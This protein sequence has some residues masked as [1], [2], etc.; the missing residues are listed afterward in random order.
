MLKKLINSHSLQSIFRRSQFAIFAITFLICTFTFLSVS[1]LTVESY[2]KQNLALIS[3]TVAERVQPALVF[4]DVLTLNEIID[5]Y[6]LQYEVKSIQVYNRN[7]ELLAQSQKQVDYYFRLENVFDRIF[8]SSPE[9]IR[10]TH[11]DQFFGEVVMFGSSKE[12]IIFIMKI[13]IG[14]ILGMFFMLLALW[15]TVNLTYHRIMKSISP[16]VQI[17]KMVSIKKAYHLRFPENKIIEFNHLNTVFN[18]LLEE[19][20][21][22]HNQLQSENSLLNYQVQHD[23]LTQLPNRN[24]FHQMLIHKFENPIQR[25]MSAVI[26]IDNN[27]FKTINDK[28][29]HLAG[30]EVLKETANRLKSSIR[31]HD[32]VARLSG[33]EFAIILD[34]VSETDYLIS[35]AEKLIKTCEKPVYYQNEEI[36]FSFSL[37]IALTRNAESIEDVMSQA[38][39]AMY[40]AKHLKNHWYIYL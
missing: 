30:D 22:W 20:H 38:D 33:D 7:G 13:L 35:I 31:Q 5:E 21:H 14:L 37:G 27:N 17:A 39:Q 15:W 19:I 25:N 28:Y 36:Y 40:K 16:I 8:L 18:Q 34:S 6:T 4:D 11:N 26:F 32:F 10:I 12:I 2:I 24:Y 3:K 29:G 1:I 23:D 9:K